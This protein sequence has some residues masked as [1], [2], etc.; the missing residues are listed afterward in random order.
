MQTEIPL[1]FLTEGCFNS[2][3]QDSV[4]WSLSLETCN[5]ATTVRPTTYLKEPYLPVIQL[6]VR[7]PGRFNENNKLYYLFLLL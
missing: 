5:R 7:T 4:R 2:L 1:P 3:I 6:Y